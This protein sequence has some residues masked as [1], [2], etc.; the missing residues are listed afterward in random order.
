MLWRDL[1]SGPGWPSWIRALRGRSGAYA[2][3]ETDSWGR[4]VVY[5]GESHSGRLY[6]TITRHF[7]TWRGSTAGLRYDRG[8][9]QV[10]VCVSEASDAQALQLRLIRRLKP[11]DNSYLLASDPDFVP[12]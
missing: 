9:V 6:G 4:Q 2:I 1:G 7:Q 11:A 12:F 10:A 8:R 3:R 5:V